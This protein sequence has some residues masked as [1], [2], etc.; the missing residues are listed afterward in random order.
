MIILGIDT[1]SVNATV[2]LMN[3]QKLIA[4]YIISNDRTHSI[5]IMPLLEDMLK[6]SGLKLNKYHKMS[7]FHC[8]I[9]TK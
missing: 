2:A 4:E 6:K 9:F 7:I 5:I 1:S 3:D 8:A